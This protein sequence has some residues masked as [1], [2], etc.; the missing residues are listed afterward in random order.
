MLY[1][2][3]ALQGATWGGASAGEVSCVE[4]GGGAGVLEVCVVCGFQ[5]CAVCAEI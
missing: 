2:H 5:I 3:A 1:T 4:L